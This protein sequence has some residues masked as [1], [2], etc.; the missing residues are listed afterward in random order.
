MRTR[1]SAS[2]C[3]VPWFLQV[4]RTY[5]VIRQRCTGCR[6][7]FRF[8]EYTSMLLVYLICICWLILCHVGFSSSAR[9]PPEASWHGG[10]SLWVLPRF[11]AS[12][13]SGNVFSPASCRPVQRSRGPEVQRQLTR[14][15]TPQLSS[16]PKGQL[17]SPKRPPCPDVAPCPSAAD[18]PS[19]RVTRPACP[20]PSSTVVYAAVRFRGITLNVQNRKV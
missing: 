16:S 10:H 3:P 14:P 13:S 12:S 2:S 4:L 7:F 6:S 9:R 8:G 15:P 11:D 5:K 20:S 1:H 17:S 18:A 19:Q